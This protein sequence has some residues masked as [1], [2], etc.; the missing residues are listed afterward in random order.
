[1]HKSPVHHIWHDAVCCSVL[2]CAAVCCSVLQCVA[3]CC[4]VLQCVAH[5]MWHDSFIL[6]MTHAYVTWLVVEDSWHGL[7]EGTICDIPS[8]ICDMTHS[9]VT[10]LIRTWH[11]V[12]L[13]ALPERAVCTESSLA[14][15]IHMWQ[16]LFIC[17]MS[18]SYVTWLIH[19][20]NDS[21]IRDM[22]HSYVAWGSLS[23]TARTCCV[24]LI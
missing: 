13:S 11:E 5:H 9:Y 12:H 21:F 17:D 3:V 15:L 7:P 16:D 8:F 6:D 14:W 23:G 2:Q 1:M 24:E 22:T 20:W 19:M 10:W 18:R 4:S